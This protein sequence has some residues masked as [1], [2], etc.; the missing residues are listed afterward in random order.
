MDSGQEFWGVLMFNLNIELLSMYYVGVSIYCLRFFN[1]VEI[2][3][4]LCMTSDLRL[5]PRC[6]GCRVMGLWDARD[7]IT[8][9]E[10]TAVLS[11]MS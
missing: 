4:I 3:L 5:K 8:P 2:F 1:Q 10:L 6:V 7:E 9:R 11:S